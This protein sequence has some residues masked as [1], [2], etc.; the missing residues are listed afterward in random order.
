M[1]KT[2]F[3]KADDIAKDSVLHDDKLNIDINSDDVKVF[4]SD[5]EMANQTVIGAAVIKNSS[6]DNDDKANDDKANDDKASD[7]KANDNKAD[8]DKLKAKLNQ[9]KDTTQDKV[10]ELKETAQD[11]VDELKDKF[12]EG[13]KAAQDKLDETKDNAHEL[14]DTAKDKLD[15]IKAT[16]Q[17]KLDETKDKAA[18]LKDTAQ[19]KID[20]LKEATQDKV[21]TLKDKLNEGKEVAQDKIDE[22]KAATQD[23]LETAKDKFDELKDNTQQTIDETKDKA[24]S[25]TDN[26]KDEL[27]AKK[28]QLSDKAQALADE[29][30]TTSDNLKQ[31]VQSK[32]DDV[33]EYAEQLADTVKQSLDNVKQKM[34]QAKDDGVEKIEDI[35]QDGEDKLAHAKEKVE[36]IKEQAAEMG[37]QAKTAAE[38]LKQKVSASLDDAMS[39]AS[40]QGLAIK[41]GLQAGKEELDSHVA[42][43]KAF[44]EEY[45]EQHDTQGLSGKLGMLGAY[46]SSV[47][48]NKQGYQAVDSLENQPKQFKEQGNQIG[49]NL[50]VGQQ[51]F[52]QNSARAMGLAG[53]F[54]PED[55]RNAISEMV[56]GK[57]ATWANQWATRDLEKV[58]DLDTLSQLDDDERELLADEISN[59]SR[60]LATLGGVT[61]LMGLK[62]VIFDTAWL[63]MVALKSVYQLSL[64][65]NRPLEGREGIDLAY[66]VLSACDLSKV[67][68]KQVIMIALAL[69]DSVLKNAQQTSL[70]EELKKVGSRYQ[71]R[72]YSKQFDELSKYIDLDKLNPKWLHYILPMGSVA[73]SAHYNNEL[74]DE[75]LGVARATFQAD[76]EAKITGLLEDKSTHKTNEQA[77]EQD[78]QA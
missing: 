16:A 75:V 11:K 45:Q 5:I 8:L 12:D 17:D 27:L 52:G 10:D 53:R 62:G 3:P 43:A 30:Q 26:L 46:L 1:T 51:L 61:G 2:K 40:E 19:D 77:D 13:K 39:L 33:K 9:A 66:G 56:Y 44:V 54:I 4:A 37:N 20:D 23:K 47:Y 60:A 35:K 68:E 69:G 67:Q 6:H 28:E 50:F 22:L 49:Q 7:N 72:S 36:D 38:E 63:L 76:A 71:N 18:N 21:D 15:D 24:A 74:I 34:Q 55:K 70:V 78:K 73:V 41:Q 58:V 57:L 14:I 25:L 59:Q 29:V 42:D 48:Q 31:G 65:Y 64:I 32:L